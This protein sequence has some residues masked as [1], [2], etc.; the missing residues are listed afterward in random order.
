MKN[1]LYQKT[2]FGYTSLAI[3]LAV[4]L[5]IHL[6]AWI[7][8]EPL[9]ILRIEDVL[10]AVLLIPL[11][12]LTVCVTPLS[13]E[14]WFSLGLARQHIALSEIIRARPI[15]T[16]LMSGFGVHGSGDSVLWSVSG[17]QAVM[18]DLADGRHIAVSTH[19]PQRL[20]DLIESLRKAA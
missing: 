13:V 4:L 19:E 16:S 20:V 14:W 12:T 17:F 15:K 9:T 10:I 6:I 2:Q 8:N 7:T 18:M 5:F 3:F 11:L 1:P